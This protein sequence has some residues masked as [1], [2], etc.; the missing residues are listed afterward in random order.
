MASLAVMRSKNISSHN[1]I[2]LSNKEYYNVTSS[3][4]LS[5]NSPKNKISLLHKVLN[6]NYPKAFDA[7]VERLT[8]GE[9]Y[10]AFVDF[11]AHDQKVLVSNSKCIGFSFIEEGT[12]SY[13][14]N[15][16]FRTINSTERRF[17]FR[18]VGLKDFW[19]IK[20]G[21]IR[22]LRGFTL[23][24]QSIPQNPSSYGGFKGV[25]FYC[26]SELC[27]PSIMMERKRILR[28]E[29]TLT[30]FSNK[31]DF[32]V[33]EGA[34]IWADDSLHVA[35]KRPI[36]E[37]F[38]L[39]RKFLVKYGHRFTGQ[40]FYLKGRNY[41]DKS[42][43]GISKLFDEFGIKTEFFP[44]GTVLEIHFVK[45][46]KLKVYGAVSSLLF[47]AGILGHSAYSISTLFPKELLVEYENDINGFFDVVEKLNFDE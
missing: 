30:Y 2:I 5:S 28:F 34:N 16:N 6:F 21:I 33:P 32:V 18:V 40:T 4:N 10:Y 26:F 15:E 23:G 24:L 44:S 43:L 46:K 22:M 20:A 14:K 29:D 1:A 42:I 38:S 7:Y 37:Y 31:N 47:Y 9:E 19:K 3:L 27:Y 17:G 25:E 41:K 11:L 35:F 36:S 45:C 12:L 13:L 39:V 8:N